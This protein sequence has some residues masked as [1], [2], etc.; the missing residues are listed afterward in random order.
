MSDAFRHSADATF[1]PARRLL[2]VTPSD[3]ADLAVIPKALHI[4]VG[5]TI[6]I[7]GADDTDPVTLTVDAGLLPVRA[8][9]V[10]A[11]GTTATSIVAL[12]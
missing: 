5:G 4:G 1:A 6:S 2:A 3:V 8:R 12:Y 11:T 7:I 9:R 10:R